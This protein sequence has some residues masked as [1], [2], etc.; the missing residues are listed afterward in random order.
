[1]SQPKLAL[2]VWHDE[3]IWYMYKFMKLHSIIISNTLCAVLHIPLA[4]KSLQF[5]LFRIHNIPLVHPT[6]QK[7]F[8][9]TIHEEYLAI[10]LDRQYISFPLSTDI[11]A[12]QVLNGQFC[13]INTPIY[14]ADTSRSCSYILFLQNRNKIYTF[15]IL[16]VINQIHMIKL[17]S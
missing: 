15:Y 11:M 5:H 2:P 9:Y 8:Q 6:L 17:S 1:M 12:C 7:S 4:D 14:T 13:H 3:S 10:R 16:S